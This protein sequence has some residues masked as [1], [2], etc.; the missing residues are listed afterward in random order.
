MGIREYAR[1]EIRISTVSSSANFMENEGEMKKKAQARLT[2]FE[3]YVGLDTSTQRGG[4]D[5][6]DISRRAREGAQRN[7]VM[8][9]NLPGSGWI[10]TRIDAHIDSVHSVDRSETGSITG[11]EA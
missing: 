9:F 2:Q 11:P 8:D 3:S 6:I 5:E 10:D 1:H 7:V 4:G